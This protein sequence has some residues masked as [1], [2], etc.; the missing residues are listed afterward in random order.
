MSVPVLKK[1]DVTESRYGQNILNEGIHVIT[2]R[3]VRRRTKGEWQQTRQRYDK[4]PTS[5]IYTTWA[6]ILSDRN[7]F[8]T[9]GE[10]Q[11]RRGLMPLGLFLLKMFS[12]YCNKKKKRQQ[13]QTN[14]GVCV[15][16]WG[17]GGGSLL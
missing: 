2:G 7:I 9:L 4:S 13:Q 1:R 5:K 17:G 6:R 3:R 15:C 11:Q 10:R 16:V 12:E 8:C 14:K